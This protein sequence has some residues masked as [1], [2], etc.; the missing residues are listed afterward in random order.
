MVAAAASLSA[1]LLGPHT[2][3]DGLVVAAELE[4]SGRSVDGILGSLGALQELIHLQP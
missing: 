3:G 1:L 2:P 4:S